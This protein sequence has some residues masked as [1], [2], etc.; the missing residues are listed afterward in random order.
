MVLSDDVVRS[1]S[2]VYVRPSQVVTYYSAQANPVKAFALKPHFEFK[3]VR[4]LVNQKVNITSIE[5]M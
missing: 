5:A 3:I 4:K 2:D 1:P